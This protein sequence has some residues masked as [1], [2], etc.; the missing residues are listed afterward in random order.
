MQKQNSTHV[1]IIKANFSLDSLTQLNGKEIQTHTLIVSNVSGKPHKIVLK[2]VKNLKEIDDDDR[3]NF[4]PIFYDDS[5]GRKQKMYSM[6]RRSFSILAMGF[7]GKKALKWK[8]RF[9]DA[10]ELMEQRLL[11]QQNH[12]WKQ[13]RI[14]GKQDRH[15]LTDAIKSLVELAESSGSNNASTY[16]K[17]FSKMVYQQLFNINKVPLNFRDSLGQGSLKQLRMIEWQ[18]AQWLNEAIETC[19][20][21]HEPYRKIKEKIKALVSVI[22]VINLNRQI[23]E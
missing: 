14:E 23:S 3:L 11:Q 2:A 20:D 9:Y 8:N 4:V 10:F 5:Y 17:N 7:T 21:Y 12:S 15:E 19:N 16:Y 18:T 1:N 6:D 22:G 13:S